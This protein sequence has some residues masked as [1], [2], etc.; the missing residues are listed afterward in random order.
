M[1]DSSSDVDRTNLP[2]PTPFIIPERGQYHVQELVMY[3]SVK[4][5]WAAYLFQYLDN[6]C[7]T[8][9]TYTE[10]ETT[11]TNKYPIYGCT[12][13]RIPNIDLKL[14]ER[15]DSKTKGHYHLKYYG[16][17]EP[18]ESVVYRK[19]INTF[20]SSRNID[21]FLTCLGL[22]KEYEYPV[23]GKVYTYNNIKIRTSELLLTPEDGGLWVVSD[24][25]LLVEISINLPENVDYRPS[26]KLLVDFGKTL[27]P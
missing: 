24:K 18:E 22:Q 19:C 11:Y 3:G 2:S 15:S 10:H 14:R 25:S 21:E 9:V 23:H 1:S 27:D 5:E 16:H 13:E 26:A 4:K 6:H 12:R 17:I 20:I 8:K 7:V